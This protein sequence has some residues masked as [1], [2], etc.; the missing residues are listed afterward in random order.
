[1][2]AQ[3]VA[4]IRELAVE[5]AGKTV[6]ID[7]VEYSTTAL[8]DPRKPEKA[9]ATLKLNTLTGLA[10]YLLKHTD[11]LGPEDDITVHV[12]DHRTVRV[13]GNLRISDFNQRFVFAEASTEIYEGPSFFERF[14]AA[15]DFVIG[16]QA[17]FVRDTDTD[18]VLKVVGTMKEEAVQQNND[19][20]VTQTVTARQGVVRVAAV[21]APNPVVLRPYRTFREVKQP[22][23]PFVLRLKSQPQ[24]LPA[25]GLFQA[26]G[27]FWI[28]EAIENVRGWLH[29]QLGDEYRILA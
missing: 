16:L 18:L 5:A 1:M 27:K 19:D 22:A 23:S 8:H 29:A 20:G 15:E 14:M 26:D 9:P 11:M 2:E 24:G 10:A 7:S 4:Q 28:L 3:A 21:D 6:T 17:L 25:V 12:V 13:I